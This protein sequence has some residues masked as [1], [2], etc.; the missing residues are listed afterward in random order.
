[1]AT[2]N[3]NLSDTGQ[4]PAPLHPYSI[5]LVVSQWNTEITEGLYQGAHATLTQFPSIKLRK[6]AVPGSFELALGAQWA[7]D[8]GADAVICI[9]SLIRGETAHFDYVAQGTTQGIKDVALKTGK[10]VIFCVL[11]D[12]NAEQAR[13]RSGGAHGNKGV[14]A[15]ATV[16]HMLRLKA[17]LQHDKG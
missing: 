11:T 10:P 14:E 9:G 7:I 5:A 17:E 6:L 4:L 3:K 15:A 16:L 2:A 13:A 1:M 12:E 8:A